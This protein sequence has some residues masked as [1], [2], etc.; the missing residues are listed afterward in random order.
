M[1]DVA[2]AR[3]G[4]VFAGAGVALALFIGTPTGVV[5]GCALVGLGLANTVPVLFRAAAA[6]DP[7]GQGAGLALVTGVGYFGFLVGPPLVGFTAEAVGLPRAMLLVIG[8]GLALAAVAGVLRRVRTPSCAVEADRDRIDQRRLDRANQ[9]G[10]T[11][12]LAS[13]TASQ[14]RE[15]M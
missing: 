7:S 1:G 4:G 15:I 11:G 14:Q 8:G 6:S 13:G 9:L 10:P 5:A 3:V 2:M 12:A